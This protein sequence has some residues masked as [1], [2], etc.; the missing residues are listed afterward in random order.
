[1]LFWAWGLI[2][3]GGSS[4]LGSAHQGHSLP[5]SPIQGRKRNVPTLILYDLSTKVGVYAVYLMQ[6]RRWFPIP[7]AVTV[8]KETYGRLWQQ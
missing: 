2:Q 8:L 1:M 6:A 4:P 3:E 7:K 5:L